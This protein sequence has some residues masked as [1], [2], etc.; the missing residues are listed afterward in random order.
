MAQTVLE[1]VAFL[2][3]AFWGLLLLDPRR[4]WPRSSLAAPIS[5]AA[6]GERV[7]AVVPARDEAAVL[8]ETLPSLLRQDLDAFSVVLVDDRSSDG[9]A[10]VAQE[11]ALNSG[12]A[13]RLR[14]VEVE[15]PDPDCSG[16]V[17]ALAAGVAAV[18]EEGP[19]APTWYLFTDADIHH[20]VHSVRALLATA[21]RDQRDLVSVMARLST[22][23]FWEK[24][25]VPAFVFFFHLLYPFRLVAREG[26]AV[27]AAAGGCVLVRRETL[28]AAGGVAAIRRALIDDVALAHAV[29]GA[30]G[31]LWIGPDAGIASVRVY[32][33]LCDVWKM[34]GLLCL[35]AAAILVRAACRD[36]R[37]LGVLFRC[38]ADH[39]S[40]GGCELRIRAVG[41]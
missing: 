2:G 4:R 40:P 16:K 7:V 10:R 13:D 30:G 22:A 14:V 23:I 29:K 19:D 37:R 15:A 36:R 33:R 39:R 6:V 20:H 35:H 21:H 31:R 11:V 32:P 41:A 9:T 27:A 18:E 8:P 17:R 34:V 28:V 25:L 12:R 3:L 5:A 24:L 38:P 26:S 1:L